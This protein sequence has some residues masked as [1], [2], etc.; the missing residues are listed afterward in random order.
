MAQHV[1]ATIVIGFVSL[2]VAML[3]TPAD[4]ISMIVALVPIFVIAFSAYLFGF[5]RGQKQA[6]NDLSDEG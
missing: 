6:N 5:R 3:V 4:P 1:T 2:V